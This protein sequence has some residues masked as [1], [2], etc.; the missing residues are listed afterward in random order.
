M[1]KCLTYSNQNFSMLDL[2]LSNPPYPNFK[3]NTFTPT[4]PKLSFFLS[5]ILPNNIEEVGM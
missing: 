1:Q 4:Y 5:K 2:P 3:P